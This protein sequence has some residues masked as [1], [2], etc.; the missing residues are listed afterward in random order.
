M[1]KKIGGLNWFCCP[2]CGKKLFPLANDAFCRGV[3][4]KCRMCKWEGEMIIGG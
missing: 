1:V 4:C 3:L 2:K